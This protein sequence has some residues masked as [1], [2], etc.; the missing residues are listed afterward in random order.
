MNEDRV[1]GAAKNVAGK[2]EEGFGR[3]AGDVKSQLQGKARQIEG[4]IQ[5]FYGQAKETATNAA[6]AV[7]ESASEAEDFLRTTIEQRP[8]T[9]AAVALGIGYLIGRFA[10]RDY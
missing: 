2:V 1:T 7:R 3:A 10:H 6:E 4:E 9:T 8:Y 5:D